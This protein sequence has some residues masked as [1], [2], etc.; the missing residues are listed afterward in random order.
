MRI[1]SFAVI[2]L[3]MAVLS[4]TSEQPDPEPVAGCQDIRQAGQ[5]NIL[6]LNTVFDA[7]AAVRQKSWTDIAQ[8][9]VRNNVHVLLIQ[10]AVFTD[11][12]RL[13]NL[14]GTSN[15]ARDL[16][17]ILNQESSEPYD[18]RVAWESGSPLVLSTANAVLSRCTITQDSQTFLPIESET[19][20]EGFQL[21]TTRNVQAA[22]LDIPGYGSLHLYNTHLCSDCP[23][24]SLEQ[25]VQA[26][27][28]V[29]GTAEA[30]GRGRSI[31]LG[32]DFNLDLAKGAGE[33]A[34]Y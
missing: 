31:V 13:Q 23:V 12:D 25:Q 28:S 4:C 16:Q 10:E 1:W 18:L 8:Y 17:R 6:T 19:V 27:V 24:Q 5:L 30:R 11:I 29:I 33:Q 20:F 9:A 15:S 3:M 26:L 32:G 34:I 21:K 14:L 7:P 22:H 2:A